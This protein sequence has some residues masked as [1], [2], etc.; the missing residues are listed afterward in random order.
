LALVDRLVLDETTG[1]RVV[2]FTMRHINNPTLNKQRPRFKLEW[3]RQLMGL[4]DTLNLE[5]GVVHQDVAARNL[6]ID[7]DSDSIVLIDFNAAARVGVTPRLWRGSEEVHA[8]YDDVK[9]VM[10]FLYKLITQ[11][12]ALEEA[13]ALDTVD[14]KDIANP[15]KWTKHPDVELDNDV[16]DFYFELMAWVRG[17][18][19]AKPMAH[20]TE[21]PRHLDWPD[22]QYDEWSM[23]YVAGERYRDGLP[24]LEWFVK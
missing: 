6:I 20:H 7:P 24:Y 16:A 14:E 5:H 23:N 8:G 2:G 22:V 11:D 21:A 15:A 10:V 13:Y 19:A 12:P 17:R 9:G 1:S 18:R 3:L 4:V